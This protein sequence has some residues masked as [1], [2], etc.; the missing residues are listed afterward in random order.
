MCAVVV[1]N[2]GCGA[3]IALNHV[4]QSQPDRYVLLLGSTSTPVLREGS[5]NRADDATLL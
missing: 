3:S 1:E 4:A 5:S 2:R